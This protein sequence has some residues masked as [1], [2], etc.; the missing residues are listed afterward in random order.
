MGL[1]VTTC[2]A[3]YAR[4]RAFACMRC[5]FILSSPIPSL[6]QA[7]PW[8]LSVPAMQWR[9]CCWQ[10]PRLSVLLLQPTRPTRTH[11]TRN[12]RYSSAPSVWHH[13][14][15]HSPASSDYKRGHPAS[16]QGRYQWWCLDCGCVRQRCNQ[17]RHVT[18]V[19]C[20]HRCDHF[21]G[22]RVGSWRCHRV[23]ESH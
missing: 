2:R 8:H 16:Q 21:G 9:G 23:F 1:T 13:G 18:W 20:R 15:P 5:L 3:V 6:T 22:C 14:P 12:P 19:G 10:W 7:K 4:F 11:N 17:T